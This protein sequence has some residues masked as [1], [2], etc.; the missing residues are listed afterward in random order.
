M[1]PG[2]TEQSPSLHLSERPEY[3]TSS[4]TLVD[5]GCVTTSPSE[6]R[7]GNWGRAPCTLVLGGTFQGNVVP[8]A[9][10][11]ADS[12]GL[13]RAQAWPGLSFCVVF[14]YLSNLANL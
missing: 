14:I 9:G 2:Q 13:Y 10:D 11:E 8:P 3:N 5:S 7:K 12:R 6:I 1:L 4:V